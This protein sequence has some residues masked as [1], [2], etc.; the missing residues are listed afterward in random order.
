MHITLQELFAYK[1][2]HTH[3]IR[4]RR[5]YRVVVVVTRDSSRSFMK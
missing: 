3:T 5:K 4:R 2:H 1:K